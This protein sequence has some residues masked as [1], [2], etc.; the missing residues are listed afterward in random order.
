MST[1]CYCICMK[2]K[3][4]KTTT[5]KT[6]SNEKQNQQLNNNN[7]NNNVEGKKNLRQ[8]IL[9]RDR[10]TDRP[11]YENMQNKLM[12][13]HSRLMLSLLFEHCE[14]KNSAFCMCPISWR[15]FLSSCFLLVPSVAKL[16][17]RL[18]FLCCFVSFSMVECA[19]I[20]CN[21]LDRWFFMLTATFDI[22]LKEAF[23]GTI[24]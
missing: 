2:P 11:S 19:C 4:V 7:N 8:E 17:A 9:H 24:F 23:I 22:N 18:P 6:K 14:H 1:Q 16:H 5:T 20:G 10:P 13:T 21:K 3:P 15:Y 12:F